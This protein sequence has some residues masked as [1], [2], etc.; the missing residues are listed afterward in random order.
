MAAELGIEFIEPELFPRHGG[1]PNR[2]P[3][4]IRKK[5]E[6]LERAE[7][8]LRE[9]SQIQQEDLKP[10]PTRKGWRQPRTRKRKER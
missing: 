2:I 10:I 1:L 6:D 4:H 8:E 7:K 5:I 3:D 9:Q